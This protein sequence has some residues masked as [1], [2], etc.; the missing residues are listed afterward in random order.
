MRDPSEITNS[1]SG[2][3]KEESREA[4]FKIQTLDSFKTA[5]SSIENRF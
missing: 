3:R 5:V 1:A 4:G 2:M